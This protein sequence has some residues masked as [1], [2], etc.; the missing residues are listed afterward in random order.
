MYS[1]T[2]AARRVR[3]WLARIFH[4][5]ETGKRI[6]NEFPGGRLEAGEAPAD[7][8]VYF[9]V[10]YVD[11]ELHRELCRELHR[12]GIPDHSWGRNPGLVHDKVHG[13]VFRF[14]SR[15]SSRGSFPFAE[16]LCPGAHGQLTDSA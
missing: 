3:G 9:V 6:P 7:Y 16:R 15:R 8:A 5:P 4:T 1:Q 2:R 14:S 10:N 13:V 11:P 12:T